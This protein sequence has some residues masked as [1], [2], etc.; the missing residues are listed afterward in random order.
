MGTR[1]SAPASKRAASEKHGEVYRISRTALRNCLT[2]LGFSV[3]DAAKFMKCP[4]SSVETYLAQ[5]FD[6]PPLRSK[7]L[8]R[9]FWANVELLLEVRNGRKA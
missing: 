1:K 3:R 9:C 8:A 7:R 2:Q 4:K 5:G 6:I